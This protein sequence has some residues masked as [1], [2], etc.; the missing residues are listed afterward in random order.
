MLSTLIYTLVSERLPYPSIR[1]IVLFSKLFPKLSLLANPLVMACG[2]SCCGVEQTGTTSF[3]RDAQEQPQ[4]SVRT[5]GLP[6]VSASSTT[7]AST[8][9]RSIPCLGDSCRSPLSNDAD[10]IPPSE[11]EPRCFSNVSRVTLSTPK[12]SSG[13]TKAGGCCVERV[14]SVATDVATS[15]GYCAEGATTV[16]Q[17]L[18]ST[19][20]DSPAYLP[21][22]Q[23]TS[24]IC[25]SS[26]KRIETKLNAL[27]V[28]T[29]KSEVSDI[30][31]TGT[32]K[33]HVILSV[34]GMTCT[35]CET[36]LQRTLA[37]LPYVR[38]LR[39]SLILAR[40]EFDIVGN[41]ATVEGV[42]KHLTRTTEFRCEQV[43][44]QGSSID[45]TCTGKA[46]TVTD[47]RWPEG[48]LDVR[49]LD[50]DTVRI[51]YD[52]KVVGARH[53][54]EKGWDNTMQLAPMRLDPSLDTGNR[55]V[56]HMGIL[57]LLSVCL[58]IPVLVMAW[59]SLPDR[60][61]AYNSASLA[62]ATI[63]QVCIAG[64][65]YPK[66]LKALVFSRVIEMDLLIVLSTSA[67]YVFSVVSFGY[68]VAG[69]PL[70]TG[71][72]FETSTLL[73]TLIMVGRWVASL[74]RQKVVYA[75]SL[76]L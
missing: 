58:T 53:L 69:A 43:S 74:A 71:E 67:A 62:L 56:W 30:E 26:E 61:D 73:V 45:L 66:A 18:K 70:P 49:L 8:E 19:A 63:V 4:R 44:T 9:S 21:A 1:L 17:P 50:K 27:E 2:G 6:D 16:T 12:D 64:P 34:S 75:A 41:A 48:V 33:E 31:K 72:F 3:V 68:M 23:N 42:I 10:I 38:Q 60:D 15:E 25:C 40:A 59:A 54:L 32:N 52:A 14:P 47:G 29:N 65:F 55:H 22:S 5:A 28:Q 7:R 20:K 24:S 39:T 35:G 13:K 51:A 76:S 36:K 46:A 11:P 37:K 57:T